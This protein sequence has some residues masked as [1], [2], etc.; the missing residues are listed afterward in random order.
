MR[1]PLLAAVRRFAMGRSSHSAL[2]A[3]SFIAAVP[4]RCATLPSTSR[5]LCTSSTKRRA[6]PSIDAIRRFDATELEDARVD[7][8][9]ALELLPPFVESTEPRRGELLRLLSATHLRLGSALDAE[10]LLTDALDIEDRHL[11]MK[12]EPADGGAAR[13]ETTFLLGVVYQKS[14]REEQALSAFQSV[15]SADDGHWR[16]R[17]H[18]ALL[19][20]SNE[21]WSEAEELLD[22]V[23]EQCP[24]HATAADLLEKL[25]VRRDAEANRIEL[26][27]DELVNEL[28]ADEKDV[29]VAK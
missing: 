21:T 5:L 6:L 20:I 15:L 25:K 14:G 24:G 9:Q 12:G 29:P 2:G 7:L 11:G 8:S 16:A 10:D 23:L 22:G 13:R 3:R 17:F 1:P 18:L 4:F 28:E 26:S 19:H 27:E